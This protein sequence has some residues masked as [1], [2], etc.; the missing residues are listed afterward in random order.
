MCSGYWLV[1]VVVP[2]GR[3][4]VCDEEEVG[5]KRGCQVIEKRN[6]VATKVSTSKTIHNAAVATRNTMPLFRAMVQQLWHSWSA[7]TSEKRGRGRL[8]A[9]MQS[10][11]VGMV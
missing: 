5:E 2:S 11:W 10:V 9:S 8:V 4:V 1:V 3:C 7:S 6:C